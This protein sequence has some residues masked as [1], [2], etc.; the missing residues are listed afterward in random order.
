MLSRHIPHVE[1]TDL[2]EF[3][4]RLQWSALRRN[5]HILK[6]HDR[7]A[8]LVA[9]APD[10]KQLVTLDGD[11]TLRRWE[12]PAGKSLRSEMLRDAPDVSCWAISADSRW[13]ALGGGDT[14]HVFDA[15][16]GESDPSVHRPGTARALAFSADGKKLAAVWGDGAAQIWDVDSAD[17]VVS[18]LLQETD[19]LSDLE[20][21]KG[22]G[23]QTAGICSSS[24]IRENNLITWLGT[25]QTESPIRTEH[26]STV[27]SIALSRDG[28]WG[29]TGDANGQ[30]CLWNAETHEQIGDGLS[31]HR[32]KVMALQFSPDATLLAV[33]A[34]GVRRCAP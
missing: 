2:R 12:L 11:L 8:R 1:Q 21:V 14:V 33:R 17:Q 9:F 25:D 34:A 10:G 28:Q 23:L 3:A 19:H 29:A 20:R 30:V 7:G 31:I 26:E 27:Y 18:W 5:S 22:A 6:E 13:I 24:V 4:W 32:G 15:R 16:S